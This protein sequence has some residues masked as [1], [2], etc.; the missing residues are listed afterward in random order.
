MT[1]MSTI[2]TSPRWRGKRGP[3]AASLH[4]SRR[5][6]DRRS[7]IVMLALSLSLAATTALREIPTRRAER[8]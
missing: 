3:A 6:R 4:H 5:M 2:C 7:W 8:G 1:G